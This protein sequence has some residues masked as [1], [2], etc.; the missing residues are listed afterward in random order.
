MIVQFT[1]KTKS[2]STLHCIRKNGTTTWTKLRSGMESHDL[3]HYVIEKSLGYTDAFFG[4]VNTGATIEDFELPRDQR[5]VHLIPKNLPMHALLAEHMVNLFCIAHKEA[6]P[7]EEV[8]PMLKDILEAHS[9]VFPTELTPE[10]VTEIQLKLKAIFE[11]W[12]VL[13]ENEMLKLKFP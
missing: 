11:A 4:L 1:K 7:N 13:K 10:K 6:I 8:I 5:P 2:P 12:E 3:A 9:I